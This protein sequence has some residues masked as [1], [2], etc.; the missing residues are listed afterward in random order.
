VEA[1]VEWVYAVPCDSLNEIAVGLL[2]AVLNGREDEV[3]DLAKVN[4]LR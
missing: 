1:G 2:K 3:I 4:L